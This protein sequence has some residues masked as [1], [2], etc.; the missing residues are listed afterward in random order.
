MSQE[1]KNRCDECGC[2][3]LEDNSCENCHGTEG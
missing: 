3:L 2:F 1:G